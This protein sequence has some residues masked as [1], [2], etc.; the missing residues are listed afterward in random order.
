MMN[1]PTNLTCQLQRIIKK[2]YNLEMNPECSNY[3]LIQ[4]ITFAY[5]IKCNKLI[6]ISEEILEGIFLHF[7]SE[8]L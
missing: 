8:L 1:V 2:N 4:S 5:L 7:E 6:E 3:E